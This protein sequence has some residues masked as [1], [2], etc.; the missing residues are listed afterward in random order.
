MQFYNLIW[1]SA[2]CLHQCRLQRGQRFNPWY[3]MMPRYLAYNNTVDVVQVT[4]G[5]IGVLSYMR[6]MMARRQLVQVACFVCRILQAL[7]IHTHPFRATFAPAGDAMTPTGTTTMV[8]T[9]LKKHPGKYKAYLYDHPQKVMV[10]SI[11]SAAKESSSPVLAASIF[12]P[13]LQPMSPRAKKMTRQIAILPP[14]L[15]RT[16]W[17]KLNVLLI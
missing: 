14:T 4:L 1:V 7:P 6:S 9:H 12:K 2:E 15:S 17:L 11:L 5:T 16:A 3:G 13:E 10:A 8:V